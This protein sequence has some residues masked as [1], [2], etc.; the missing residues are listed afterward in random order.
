MSFLDHLEELTMAY[1]PSGR[2]RIMVAAT[3]AFIAKGF[4]FDVLIFG[5]TKADFFTYEFLCKASKLLGF[6]SFCD[7][8]FDFEVQSRTMAGQ[9]SAHIWT[10][11]TFGLIVA[12]PYVSV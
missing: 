3:A 10:S 6:E 4:V 8:N 2:R 12:F 5:P 11:I 7:T 1:Y 9:F